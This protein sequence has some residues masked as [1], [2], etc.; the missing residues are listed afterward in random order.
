MV[1]GPVEQIAKTVQAAFELWR[2]FIATREAAY[3]RHMDKRMRVAINYGEKY[4]LRNKELGN[5]KDD[6]LLKVYSIRF[7]KYNN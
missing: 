1:A 7:F 3:R 5:D 4:I 6:R 2:E